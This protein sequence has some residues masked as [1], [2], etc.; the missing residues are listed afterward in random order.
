MCLLSLF[1][2]YGN[3]GTEMLGDCPQTQSNW[4]SQVATYICGLCD[5]ELRKHS[6]GCN[7]SFG[8]VL[9]FSYHPTVYCAVSSTTQSCIWQT[10]TSRIQ[11]REEGVCCRH[12]VLHGASQQISFILPACLQSSGLV[13]NDDCNNA[14]MTLGQKSALGLLHTTKW[15]KIIYVIIKVLWGLGESRVIKTKYLHL[16]NVQ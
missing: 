4:W 12:C 11:C 10:V 7:G 6:S 3:P 13:D 16:N 14:L 5:T 9:V 1:P 2:G 8:A 15:Y